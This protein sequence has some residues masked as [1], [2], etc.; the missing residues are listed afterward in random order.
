MAV[1]SS[2]APTRTTQ[3]VE[4]GMRKERSLWGDA[5]RRLTRNK[6]AIGGMILI[7]L[8]ALM[9]ISAS[10]IAPDPTLNTVT[11]NAFRPPF[12][13]KSDNPKDTGST[14]YPLGTDSIGRDLMSKMQRHL[15]R[16]E[17]PVAIIASATARYFIRQI[18]ETSLPN[19]FIV[20]HNE[21]PPGVRVQSLGTIG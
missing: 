6:A 19:A 13:V 20:S 11:N 4:F 5:W 12:W 2:P 21:I 10:W 7:I 9:A 17:M 15:Q 16:P 8:F 1:T 3:G 18:V 14:E